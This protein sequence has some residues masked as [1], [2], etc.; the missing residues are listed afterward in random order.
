MPPQTLASIARLMPA[1]MARSQISGPQAAIS[2]LLAVTT[3][4]RLSMAASMISAATPVPP[5]SSA[6]ICTSGCDDH[7]APVRGLHHGPSAAGRSSCHRAAADRR[8]LQPET[9]L[10]RDLLGIFG[11]DGERS[12]ADIPGPT[13][14]TLTSSIIVS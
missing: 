4:L 13:M 11:Q 7:F 5:T 12:R 1:W 8:H 6:T 14:P 3:D 10:E 2:S 9:E